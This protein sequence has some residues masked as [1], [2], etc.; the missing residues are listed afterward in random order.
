M[1]TSALLL[2]PKVRLVNRSLP[3]HLACD[4]MLDGCPFLF[5][6]NRTGQRAIMC[7]NEK[8]G[9]T[10]WMLLMRRAMAP[11]EGA[12][13]DIMRRYPMGPYGAAAESLSDF[14][15]AAEDASVPRIMMV[16]NP[17]SRL[18]SAFTDK[19]QNGKSHTF[20][21]RSRKFYAYITQAMNTTRVNLLAGARSKPAKTFAGFT[22][23]LSG[24][25]PIVLRLDGHFAPLALHCGNPELFDYFLHVEDMADWYLPVVRALSLEPFASHGWNVSVAAAAYPE[26]ARVGTFENDCFYTPHAKSC[27]TFHRNSI[28]RPS[29]PRASSPGQYADFAKLSSF[30][31]PALADLVTKWAAR[32][33]SLFGYPP[34][35]LRVNGVADGSSLH[36]HTP[37]TRHDR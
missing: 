17:Y 28:T 15:R 29:I 31:T 36:R 2:A 30:F 33:L 12:V 3:I 1:D 19:L 10:A 25:S 21:M 7:L 4:K 18:L 9:S 13:T 8:V 34:L 26:Y 27:E 14:T 22:T 5:R 6:N 37:W 32:D 11:A 16:R 35:E 24:L 23:A 20:S